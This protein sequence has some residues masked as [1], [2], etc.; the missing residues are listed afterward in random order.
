MRPATFAP[1]FASFL[2]DRAPSYSQA[3]DALGPR[4]GPHR[5]VHVRVCPSPHAHGLGLRWATSS[6]SVRFSFLFFSFLLLFH[7]LPF[8]LFF[9]VL[10]VL[11]TVRPLQAPT[12]FSPIRLCPPS[13][14]FAP[15]APRSLVTKTTSC[16]TLVHHRSPLVRHRS[17]LVRHRSPLVCPFFSCSSVSFSLFSRPRADALPPSLPGAPPATQTP[18]VTVLRGPASPILAHPPFSTPRTTAPP[19]SQT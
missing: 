3:R 8:S 18:D 16:L 19:R 13:L 15:R 7:F 5:Q 6:P 4:L 9:S 11:L 14:S 2:T 17:P 10:S 1:P 12:S